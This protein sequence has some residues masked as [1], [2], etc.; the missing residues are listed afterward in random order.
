MYSCFCVH[1]DKSLSCLSFISLNLF[2]RCLFCFQ[3][4]VFSQ[5]KIAMFSYEQAVAVTDN[6]RSVLSDLQK[7]ALAMV[8]TPWDNKLVD[9][10]G[11]T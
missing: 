5:E 3:K 1:L 10:R 9:F 8:L 11:K 2:P 4:V 6:Q 7:T